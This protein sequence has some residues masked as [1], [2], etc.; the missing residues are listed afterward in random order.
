MMATKSEHIKRQ[1]INTI[2]VIYREPGRRYRLYKKAILLGANLFGA[3]LISWIAIIL[4][5]EIPCFIG[6]VTDIDLPVIRAAIRADQAVTMKYRTKNYS[7]NRLIHELEE[8][9]VFY[10]QI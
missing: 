3:S 5:Y 7:V 9:K 6:K 1:R 2:R 4:I 10:A 8:M